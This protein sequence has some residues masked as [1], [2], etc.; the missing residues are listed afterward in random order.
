MDTKPRSDVRTPQ[1]EDVELRSEDRKLRLVIRWLIVAI[2]VL[3]VAVLALG[4][5]LIVE[6]GSE[7]AAPSPTAVVQPTPGAGPEVW[8]DDVWRDM[9]RREG[10]FS[11]E[12]ADRDQVRAV[13]LGLV[14]LR[15]GDRESFPCVPDCALR[16]YDPVQGW[17]RFVV[18]DTADVERTSAVVLLADTPGVGSWPPPSWTVAF[19]VRAGAD[20]QLWV[21]HWETH[22]GDRLLEM[23]VI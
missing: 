23:W 19:A 1:A 14:A 3:T 8:S 22:W 6:R 2:A 7:E 4:A 12:M 13:D 15:D 18:S 21:Q 16:Q 5:A 17:G 10:E 20:D 11:F 9:W